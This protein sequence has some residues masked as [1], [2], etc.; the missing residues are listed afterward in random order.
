MIKLKWERKNMKY[1]LLIYANA[2]EAPE[3][4]PEQQQAAAKAWYTV[5]EEMKSAGVW[6]GNNGLSPVGDAKTIRIRGGKTLTT[7]GPFAET[8]EQL[9]GYYLVDCKDFDEAISWAE[10]VPGA[11]FGSIEVRPLNQWSQK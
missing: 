6:L 4:T 7:D 2:S 9:S 10:K 5:V 8:K 3:Y 11:H 1:M